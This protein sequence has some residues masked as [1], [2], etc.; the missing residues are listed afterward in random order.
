[1]S[2]LEMAQLS[3]IHNLIFDKELTL[4]DAKTEF[5]EQNEYLTKKYETIE[6]LKNIRQALISLKD[7]I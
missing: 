6:K 3:L 5:S 1:L 7:K 2:S 4:E